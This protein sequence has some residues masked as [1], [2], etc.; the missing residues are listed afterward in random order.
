MLVVAA[1]PVQRN[2]ERKQGFSGTR[3]FWHKAFQAQGFS[4]TR[5]FWHKAFQVWHK[6]FQA[7]GFSGR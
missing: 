5:L 6:A 1:G 2:R 3:L 4:G 7:Q